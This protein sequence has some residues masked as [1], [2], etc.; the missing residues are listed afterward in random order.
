MKS[1]CVASTLLGPERVT[2]E[3]GTPGPEEPSREV[4]VHEPG[5]AAAFL[6]AEHR[7][8]EQLGCAAVI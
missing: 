5:N 4:E 6:P 3:Q 2:A 1:S 7:V 8:Q